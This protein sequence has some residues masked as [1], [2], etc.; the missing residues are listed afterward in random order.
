MPEVR[1]ALAYEHHEQKR[2]EHQRLCHNQRT[3]TLAQE[4]VQFAALRPAGSTCRNAQTRE[5]EAERSAAE[6]E[7]PDARAKPGEV[8][9]EQQAERLGE[10]IASVGHPLEGGEGQRESRKP[11]KRQAQPPHQQ[12]GCG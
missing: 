11:K 12:S 6:G 4:C 10:D 2:G 8:A 7:Q 5:N 3:P 9:K 1:V